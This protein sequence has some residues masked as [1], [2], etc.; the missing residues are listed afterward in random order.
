MADQP[1]GTKYF[2]TPD[3]AGL[4]LD[5]HS[6]LEPV[7]QDWGHSP[8]SQDNLYNTPGGYTDGTSQPSKSQRILGL[9]VKT[10]WIILVVL[11]VILAGGIG[12]GIGAGLA[13]RGRAVS[14]R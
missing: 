6:G 2:A 5:Q 8:T 12:G 9:P 4:Q 11:V 7:S 1:S 14:S 3:H 13:A 10:F